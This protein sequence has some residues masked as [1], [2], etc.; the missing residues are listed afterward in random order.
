MYILTES[1]SLAHNFLA[2]IRDVDIQK[3]R[4]KFRR[5]MERIGEIM[6]YEISKHLHYEDKEVET[7]LGK[8]ATKNQYW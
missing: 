8:K 4:A 5:N 1:S 7:E 6:A 3:D 2:E